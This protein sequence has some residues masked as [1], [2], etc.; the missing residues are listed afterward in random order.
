MAKQLRELF[1]DF[2]SMSTEDQIAKVR[3][4]RH[5]RTIERPVAA[6]KREKARVKTAD[7]R[8][9]SAK[10]LLSKLT[11]EQREILLAQLKG[12]MEE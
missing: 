12:E 2:L 8:K 11:P 5:T 9:T 3:E 10:S 6:V 7:K 1:T 4:I